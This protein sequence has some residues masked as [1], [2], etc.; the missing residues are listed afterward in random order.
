MTKK[1]SQKNAYLNWDLQF[2]HTLIE[3]VFKTSIMIPLSTNMN[4]LLSP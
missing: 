1:E 2:L 4:I 3:A